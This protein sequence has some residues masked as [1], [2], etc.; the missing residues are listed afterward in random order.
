MPSPL[1]ARSATPLAIA[2]AASA[3][4]FVLVSLVAVASGAA[5]LAAVSAAGAATSIMAGAQAWRSARRQE[6]SLTAGTQA[7]LALA[8]GD[9]K[10][11]LPSDPRIA[12]MGEAFH[13]DR[14]RGHGY[15]AG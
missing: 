15:G 7:L 3:G 6:E 13:P 11:E 2:L 10:A 14:A 12:A 9:F 8:H 1:P 5:G 4:L